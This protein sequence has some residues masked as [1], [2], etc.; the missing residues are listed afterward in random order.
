MQPRTIARAL[1]RARL[2]FVRRSFE[3]DIEDELRFHL[4]MVESRHLAN[5]HSPADVRALTHKEFGS[6]NRYK[7]EVRDARGLTFVDD[8]WRDIRLAGRTLLR[9]PGFTLIALITFALGI[10]V[11]TAIFSVVN[12]V[13]LR[14]L[15]YP[16]ADRLVRV[17]ETIKD[18]PEPG[19]VSVMN[20][21][22]WRKQSTT[23]E[24]VGGFFNSSVMLDSDGDPERVRQ[25]VVSANV[26][27][28][29]GVKPL[30][31][32]PFT[33]DEEVKGKHR[34]VALSEHLWRTRYAAAR[35]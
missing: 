19:A 8:M 10:G 29:L 27:P 30:L 7:E 26:F 2:F 34:V 35:R 24:A 3:R 28:M 32:R 31:G 22:D 18:Y 4:E 16:N 5:G 33:A 13:L 12:T 1:R 17:F 14:P 25:G 20:F 15:P 21:F 6:M 23:F 9:T 11:N